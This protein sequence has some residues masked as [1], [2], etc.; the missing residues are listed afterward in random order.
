[1][2]KYDL[3]TS[4]L[5]KDDRFL[6]EEV[7]GMGQMLTESGVILR[8]S[9]E[10]FVK[11]GDEFLQHGNFPAWKANP[12]KSDEDGDGE[13]TDKDMLIYFI[14][15]VAGL[16]YYMKKDLKSADPEAFKMIVGNMMTD[17]TLTGN[18]KHQAETQTQLAAFVQKSVAQWDTNREVVKAALKKYID[19][20]RAYYKLPA[21]A[22]EKA[23]EPRTVA[24]PV[25]K[26]AVAEAERKV[27]EPK[28]KAY[29]LDNKA[30]LTNKQADLWAAN[31]EVITIE[32]VEVKGDKLHVTP[33]WD[34][35]YEEK[36]LKQL[37]RS[38]D[39]F[40]PEDPDLDHSLVE[41]K[42]SDKQ[43]MNV[44]EYSHYV[45]VNKK[46]ASGWE[47]REDA[48]DAV[49]DLPE[50]AKAKAKVFAKVSLKRQGIDPEDNN[51]WATDADLKD[52]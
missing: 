20:I 34:D 52:C 49:E 33:H 25:D 12:H 23:D 14:K 27:G 28:V 17:R 6:L 1:M 42:R 29:K 26:T 38:L 40:D 3:L 45:V 50:S 39:H 2:A 41:S 51:C 22:P 9:I 36:T 43:R 46:I 21:V 15:L 7:Y 4:V 35:A 32:Y 30:G 18:V 24:D 48:K 13:I 5:S 8:E 31:Q 47:C 10:T 11:N 19:G 37:Q 44:D 16:Y